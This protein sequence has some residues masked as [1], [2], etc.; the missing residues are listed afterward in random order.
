MGYAHQCDW[1]SPY[2]L[3]RQYTLCGALYVKAVL[4]WCD[5]LHIVA[6]IADGYAL[7][8]YKLFNSALVG[9]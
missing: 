7:A 3:R 4:L 5:G 1:E 8:C 6:D 2:P 9:R